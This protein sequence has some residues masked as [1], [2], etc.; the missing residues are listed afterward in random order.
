MGF[1]GARHQRSE[2]TKLQTTN[3]QQEIETQK[4]HHVCELDIGVCLEFGA[5]DL[6]FFAQEANLF[7][8]ALQ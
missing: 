4:S 7:P 8:V 2:S 1:G 6:E 3:K 5:W